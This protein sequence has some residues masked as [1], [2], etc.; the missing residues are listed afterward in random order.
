[1][2]AT[3][4]S[5][6]LAA[7]LAVPVHAAPV[8]GPSGYHL[9][10]TVPL[11]GDEGW[12]DL[13]LNQATRR[14]FITH[15]THVIVLNLTD[16]SVAGDIP[17]TPRVHGV[18]FAPDAGF[19]SNGGDNTVSVFDL[20]TLQTTK[21][22][23]VGT[24][25]DAIVYDPASHDVLTFNGGSKDATVIDAKTQ[26][27]VGTIPLGGKPEFAAP[28]G[29][30]KVYVNI[31]DTSQIVAIDT[32]T[33]TVATRW[34]LAPCQ[35]PSGLAIDAAHN[36]LFAVCHNKMMAVVDAL[37]GKIVATPAI[38]DGPDG[39]GF[40]PGTQLAFSSNGEGTLTVVREVSPDDFKVLDT[41]QTQKRARTM[42]LD[43]E[44]HDVFLVTADFNPPT[45]PGVRPTIVPGTV[46]LLVYA[47]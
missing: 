43:T 2:K 45:A 4:A 10:R 9:V 3:L 36:R 12:D 25:P 13:A 32:K 27:V 28:D 14:L 40:D 24:G 33:L 41:V 18:A 29:S 47:K 38:G 39:A 34:P 44:S 11:A 21:R 1:M 35:E 8:A 23:A 17:N 5:I 30:G 22:I 42:K 6:C 31:E 7:A 19:T 37:T 46:R 20:S 15:G 16:F 26:T